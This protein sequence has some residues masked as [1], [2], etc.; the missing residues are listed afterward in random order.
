MSVL[1]EL[2]SIDIDVVFEF[3]WVVS[4]IVDILSDLVGFISDNADIIFILIELD[5]V[6]VDAISELT[7][8]D[9]EVGDVIA[10]SIGFDCETVDIISISGSLII[11][12]V[13]TG[14]SSF[15]RSLIIA[16]YIIKNIAI[17]NNIVNIDINI[18]NEYWC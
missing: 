6:K 7:Q 2:D 18:V 5:S 13:L 9:S 15:P 8:F 10:V 12:R 17:I 4:N 16:K 11:G 14:S 1:N 3:V